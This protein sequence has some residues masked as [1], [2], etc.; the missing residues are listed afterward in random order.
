MVEAR[1]EELGMPTENLLTPETLRRIA[2]EPPAVIDRASIAEALA[3]REARPWQIE[4]T[5]QRIAD[6]FV[7]AAQTSDPPSPPVS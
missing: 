7:G 1:A 4:E 2:W 3:L 5:A 6:A